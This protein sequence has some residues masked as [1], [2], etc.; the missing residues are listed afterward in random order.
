MFPGHFPNWMRD[1]RAAFVAA[2]EGH[3]VTARW[4]IAG[5]GVLIAA[6]ATMCVMPLWL[7]R[8]AAGVTNL[9]FP[10]ILAPLLWA[11]LFFYAL[12]EENLVRGSVVIGGASLVQATIALLAVSG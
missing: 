6:V 8:G 7:P 4:V 3:P 11:A 5:P 2:V 9:A 10:I 1:S 12:L